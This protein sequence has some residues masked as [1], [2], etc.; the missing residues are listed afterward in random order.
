MNKLTTGAENPC[1]EVQMESEPN[2]DVGIYYEVVNREAPAKQ[3][4]KQSLSIKDPIPRKFPYHQQIL[5]IQ[6]NFLNF[7]E[8]CTL[9]LLLLRLV[10]IY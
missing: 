3:Q 10:T 6:T 7:S 9:L 4:I 1:F 2:N 8:F 5:H